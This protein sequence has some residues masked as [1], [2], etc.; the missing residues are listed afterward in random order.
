M[1]ERVLLRLAR[2]NKTLVF[3]TAAAV[4][5]LGLLL[6]G[7]IGAAV[8]LIFAAG[9][10]WLLATTWPATPPTA[11]TPRVLILILVIAIAAYKA[12]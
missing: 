9:M 11:R 6:P 7:I 3:L 5:F 10:A 4:T 1:T 8:L 2:L 12:T